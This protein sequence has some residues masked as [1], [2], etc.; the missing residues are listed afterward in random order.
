MKVFFCRKLKI[1]TPEF[2]LFPKRLH[3]NLT[4]Q[5]FD[6]FNEISKIKRPNSNPYTTFSE[7]SVARIEPVDPLRLQG[8]ERYIPVALTTRLLGVDNT[9]ILKDCI[10]GQQS[11][12]NKHIPL[13]SNSFLFF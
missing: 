8:G 3:K 13:N 9:E 11:I 1:T 7:L 12:Y 5:S 6:L 2:F 10:F 4:I